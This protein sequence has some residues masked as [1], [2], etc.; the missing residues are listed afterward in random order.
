MMECLREVF[1]TQELVEAVLR[2]ARPET[3][4][5]LNPPKEL[6]KPVTELDKVN[7]QLAS[8]KAGRDAGSDSDAGSDED[9]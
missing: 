3:N 1:G 7:P 6:S 8:S 4:E 9:E 5:R 2:L